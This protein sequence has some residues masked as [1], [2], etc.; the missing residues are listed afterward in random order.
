MTLSEL[1]QSWKHENHGLTMLDANGN[2][3]TPPCRRCQLE[4]WAK[5]KAKEWGEVDS[6]PFSVSVAKDICVDF[7]DEIKKMLGVPEEEQR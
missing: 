1:A 2:D 5:E 6:Y 7:S 4:K 3:K